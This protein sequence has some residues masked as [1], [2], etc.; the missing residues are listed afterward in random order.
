MSKRKR[1]KHGKR[2]YKEKRRVE[3]GETNG[4]K[5]EPREWRKRGKEEER[6]TGGTRAKEEKC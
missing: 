1:K 3:G 5:L 4:R 6:R 2:K